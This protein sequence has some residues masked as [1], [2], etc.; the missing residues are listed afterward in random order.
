MSFLRVLV[1]Y[2]SA[3]QTHKQGETLI[4]LPWTFCLPLTFLQQC[5][6]QLWEIEYYLK[7]DRMLDLTLVF[8]VLFP[9]W[10][11]LACPVMS[12]WLNTSSGTAELLAWP[13]PGALA[14]NRRLLLVHGNSNM[15][16]SGTSWQWPSSAS[17]WLAWVLRLA[18]TFILAE[19]A[20][21]RSPW[22]RRR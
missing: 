15:T 1:E 14:G 18:T 16:W 12:W 17:W 19:R 11:E 4:P 5:N 13:E 6:L 21:E 22:W 8:P 3:S 20:R 2:Q 9:S 10:T 7:N